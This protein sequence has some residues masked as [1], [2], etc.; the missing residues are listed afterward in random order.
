MAVLNILVDRIDIAVNIVACS[1]RGFPFK[2]PARNWHS[3]EDSNPYYD[4]R[5]SIP[6]RSRLCYP[7]TLWE[8]I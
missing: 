1:R 5:W 3:Q 8:Q 6:G 7:I 4:L 2:L